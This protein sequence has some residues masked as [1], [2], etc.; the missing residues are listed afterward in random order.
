LVCNPNNPT[1]PG[2]SHD[3]LTGFLDRVPDHVLVLLDEAYHEYVRD[4]RIPDGLDLYRSRPN[5][6]VVRTFSKAYGLAALRIGYLI[7]HE[8]VVT[9]VGKTHL[10][11]GVNRLAQAAALASISAKDELAERIDD[12]V[13][14]RRRLRDALLDRG[15]DIPLSEG[16]F[17]WLR[18]GER[19]LDFGAHCARAGIAVKAFRDEGVRVTVGT[20]AAGDAFLSAVDGW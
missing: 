5:V 15:W 8:H 19:S 2:V 16:N 11:Y 13:R 3:E 18:L 10:V 1:G 4:P 14:E 20:R 9:A 7:A 6:A 12:T 17:L